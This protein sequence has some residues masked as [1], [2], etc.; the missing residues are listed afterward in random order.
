MYIDDHGAA[1][2]TR[3]GTFLIFM[4]TNL[5]CIDEVPTLILVVMVGVESLLA[6]VA[7]I[8]GGDMR[9]RSIV[10]YQVLILLLSLET[11]I[12][13]GGFSYSEKQVYQ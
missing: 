8:I 1:T 9:L 5:S 6:D 11:S 4:E 3:L 7:H 13:T 10:R 12:A 2:L